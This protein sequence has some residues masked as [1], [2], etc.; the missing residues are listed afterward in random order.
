[1]ATRTAEAEARAEAGR[2]ARRD[3]PRSAHGRWA[4][5]ADRTDPVEVLAA[6]DADRLPWLVPVRRARMAESAF[7]FFRGSAAVMAMDLAPTP[8][9][10]VPVQLCGDA[11]LANFGT[12]ASA[13]RR[14][15]FDLND[16]DETVPGPWEWDV[17]RL[18]ASV[19]VAARDN[20]WSDTV[21]GRAA[22]GAVRT[23]ARAMSRF[24]DLPA[25]RIWYEQ[26]SL[27][28]VRRALPSKADRKVFDK[29]MAKARGRDSVRA[30]GKLA[31]TVDGR[32]RIRSQPPLLVPLRDLT[33]HLDAEEMHTRVAETFAGYV[34]SLPPDRRYLLQRF[35][36]VDV[37]LKVVGVGSVGTRC[38]VVL[39]TGRDHGEP[40]FLQ[41]KEATDSVLQ[42]YVPTR[43]DPHA[44]RRVVEG[45]RLVQASPDVFLGW[46]D[47]S[48]GRHYYWRQ[49]HDMKGSAD[50]AAMDPD[51]LGAYVELCGRTLAHAH[52]RSGDAVTIAG[53]LGSGRTF[54]DALADFAVAYAEQ[55]QAD[56]DR[57]RRS[58]ADG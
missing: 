58:V 40:L 28:D 38:W 3:V 5:P 25:L 22:R 32:L 30:L 33:E 52:A 34:E 36:V 42:A 20:G 39:L 4:P 17:K 51:R 6:Q 15:V 45:R 8:T 53:Y 13:E 31:E 56:H 48:V 44:G 12:F 47:T 41:V 19:V 35:S 24:A 9:I 29:G 11:H 50:V 10:G 7:A 49:F 1:M 21:G 14:Q 26:V 46:S 16:F 2:G 37:A 57:F 23:Y 54:A 18:A 43:P 27:A 55:N